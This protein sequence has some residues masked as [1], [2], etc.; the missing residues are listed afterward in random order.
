MFFVHAMG[1]AA[2]AWDGLGGAGVKGVNGDSGE[3]RDG[4]KAHAAGKRDEKGRRYG[5]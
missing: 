5:Q 1:T 3:K 2:R 4:R